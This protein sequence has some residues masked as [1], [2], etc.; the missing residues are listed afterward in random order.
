[1]GQAAIAP[2][3]SRLS[4]VAQFFGAH[5][6]IDNEIGRVLDAAQNQAPGALLLYTSDHG[7]FL[8]SHR[9]TDKGPA[10]YDEIT[11]VPFLAMWPG[12]APAHV[13][14]LQPRLAH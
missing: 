10:M 14:F 6:F 2:R 11:R 1:M 8:E 5:T 9:L 3:A 13:Q 4:T 7:V 12:H